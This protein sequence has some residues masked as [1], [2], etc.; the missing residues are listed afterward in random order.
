M[1]EN[2]V[3]QV[4]PNRRMMRWLVLLAAGLA[5]ACASVDQ[6]GDDLMAGGQGAYR[7]VGSGEPANFATSFDFCQQTLRYQTFGSRP[8]YDQRGA[9][10]V[11]FNSPRVN[12]TGF[13]AAPTVPDRRSFDGCMRSQGWATAES[14]P[15]PDTDPSAPPPIQPLPGTEDGPQG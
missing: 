6:P 2:G 11:T 7:W 3:S 4:S 13:P 9:G 15:S 10:S 12:Y 5:A 8:S 14:A 1:D